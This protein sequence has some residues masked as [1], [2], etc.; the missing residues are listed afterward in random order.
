M[1]I[2]KKYPLKNFISQVK[3]FATQAKKVKSAFV[4]VVPSA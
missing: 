2:L 4:K 3:Y 1:Q